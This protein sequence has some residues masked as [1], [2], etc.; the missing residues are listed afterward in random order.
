[1]QIRLAENIRTLRRKNQMTQEQ[2]AEQLNV[3]LGVV[4]KWERGASQPEIAC[5]VEIAE[6]FKVSVDSLIG[7]D[8]M[9]EN[10][11][12]IAEEIASLK[13]SMRIEEAI[14]LAQE[15]LLKFPNNLKVVV[16]SAQLFAITGMIGM[17]DN[18][19]KAIEL[20]RK[21]ITLLPQDTKGEYSEIEF[22][23]DIAYGLIRQNKV[24]EAIDVLKESNVCG[25]NDDILGEIYVQHKKDYDK[26]M[27]YL[28]T[29]A[30]SLINKFIGTVTGFVNAYAGI[31]KYEKAEQL[32][33][34]FEQ[35]TVA[36]TQDTTI[37]TFLDKLVSAYYAGVAFM[38]IENK[39]RAKAELYFQKAYVYAAKFDANPS[40]GIDNIL[41]ANELKKDAAAF[42]D[43]GDSALLAIQKNLVEESNEEA[44]DLWKE[45]V[46]K[47]EEKGADKS[48]F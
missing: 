48:I 29:S 7:Y 39:D 47:N 21:A 23:N 24:N 37:P 35:I 28:S 18:T 12:A 19:E 8:M 26:G 45:I 36:I 27:E 44:L 32:C 9:S 41:M 42:D 6:V 10:P 5:L 16:R 31:K 14:T 40:H 13:S 20:F 46:K 15:A 2:L 43:M 22:K 30:A 34:A 38:M 3:S 33:E 17:G 1:M 11:E 25:I 4:S